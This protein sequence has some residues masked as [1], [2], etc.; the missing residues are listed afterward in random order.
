MQDGAAP[1]WARTVRAH[2]NQIYENR[3]IGRDGPIPW[4]PRSPDLNPCDFFL[5]SYVKS[6]VYRGDMLIR[7]QAEQAIYQA[8]QSVPETMLRNATMAVPDRMTRCLLVAG[9]HFEQFLQ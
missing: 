5:W 6:I 1:H 2:L 7:Q 9:E 8:F 3:W 4:P